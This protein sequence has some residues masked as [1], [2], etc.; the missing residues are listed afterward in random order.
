MLKLENL[1]L[2][3]RKKEKIAFQ[4]QM[5]HYGL[6]MSGPERGILGDIPWH[7]HDEFEFGCISKGSILYRTNL[8]EY[9]LHEGDGIFINSGVLHDL[10]PLEPMEAAGLCTQF[11]DRSFLAGSPGSVF[12]IRYI[13]PVQEQRSLDAIPLY[14]QDARSKDSLRKLHECEEIGRKEE[15]FFEFRLRNLFSELWEIIYSQASEEKNRESTWDPAEDK[16]IK[17][18]LTDIQMHYQ[19]KLTAAE[20]AKNMHISEREYYRLFQNFLGS[21]PGEYITSVRLQKAQELLRCTDKSI[22]DIAMETGFGT[23]SYFC[24]IFKSHH[25]ITPNQYRKLRYS[26]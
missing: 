13:A 6:Y 26:S 10:H 5:L 24:K 11:F 19:E 18:M 14:R 7:W 16:R 1:N 20:L 8:H 2:D 17:R 22:L 3:G 21:T 25:Q 4:S 9:I 23:S 15:P 12:D